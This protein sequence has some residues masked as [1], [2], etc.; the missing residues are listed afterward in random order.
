MLLP[1][2]VY[3]IITSL[4]SAGFEAYAVGGCVRDLLL[5]LSPSDYD[6]ATSAT[7][8]EIKAVFERTHDT[9]IKHGTITV[10]A[11]DIPVEVTTFRIDGEYSDNRRPDS[12]T[13]TR[14]LRDDLSRR[15]FTVNAMAYS[16]KTGLID[17]F[18]GQEDLKSKLIRAVGD[19]HKR[20]S[21][22]GLRIMRAVRFA[23]VYRFSIEP[24]TALA[25][26]E[27][28]HL[29]RGI[30]G[31]R[32]AAE[33]N[34]AVMGLYGRDKVMSLSL[35]F[36]DY[37]RARA[38]MRRL[39]YDNDTFYKVTTLLKYRGIVIK[40]CKK[41]VKRVLNR[42]G[43]E[44]FFR[45]AD[46]ASAELAREIIGNN[47]CYSLKALAVK[48]GDLV[49]LGY[50]GAQVGAQLNRLLQAVISGKCKNEKVELLNYVK[51]GRRD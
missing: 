28:R 36:D 39:K 15:D 17:L 1:N 4:E 34:K 30:A 31:E 9:G 32:I 12:V 20:F 41:A 5:G 46:K 10:I 33:L 38:I 37:E 35:F 16:E 43:E 3:A 50:N 40:P 14:C 8:A 23:A 18:G 25:M 21:E 7:P 11:D 24:Q 26:E 13:F 27:L 29:I 44:M 2:Y 48:G 6:I 19:P 42:F 22:D 51:Y 49:E 45:L 47:E